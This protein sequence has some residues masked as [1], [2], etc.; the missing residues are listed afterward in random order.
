MM[1]SDVPAAP[2]GAL[3]KGP[4]APPPRSSVIEWS[5]VVARRRM[6]IVILCIQEV[7]AFE[8]KDRMSFVHA[9]RGR[10]DVD[11]SLVEIEHVVGRAFLRVHRRWLVNVANIRELQ[12][13][14]DGTGG[15]WVADSPADTSM[16]IR[17][18]VARDAARRVRDRLLEGTIGIRHK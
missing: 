10:F 18:P 13:T 9:A 8:A 3:N 4:E 12:R 2:R 7:W 1:L 14:H 16:G 5:R 17:V 15:L 11:L 6:S